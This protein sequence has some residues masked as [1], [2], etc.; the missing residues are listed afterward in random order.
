MVKSGEP[1]VASIS[2]RRCSLTAVA[3][4]FRMKCLMPFHLSLPLA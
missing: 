4:K 1:P 3:E 2:D